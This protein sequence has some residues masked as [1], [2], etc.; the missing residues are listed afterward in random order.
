M[1]G[2]HGRARSIVVGL[3]AVLAVLALSIALLLI[4]TFR[5]VNDT[6][7]FVD[8]V[9]SIIT[10]PDVA[11]AIGDVAAAELVSSLAVQ[12]RIDDLLPGP[13]GAVAEPLASAAQSY[14]AEGT[15]ALLASEQFNTAWDA[16][17]TAG[18][19]ATI[20]LLSGSDTEAVERSGGVIVINVAPVASALVVQAAGYLS[21]LLGVD[22]DVSALT[23]DDV[24]GAVAGLEEQLGV[25]LP[26]DF[27]QIVLFESQNLAGA[28]EAYQ[29]T[30]TAVWLAPVAGILLAVLA[31]ALAANRR[32]VAMG[33]VVGVALLML[34][35]GLALRPLQSAILDAVADDGLDR[36]VATGLSTVFSSLQTG[37]VVVVAIG[38]AA[39]IL[40]LLSGRSAAARA[41]Q[42]AT[43]PNEVR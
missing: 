17:L 6:E 14:L 27:G 39:A 41:E 38:V 25:D 11:M 40:L 18:H 24:D 30:A 10:E 4:W 21:D 7:V 34:L 15:T 29:A 42:V 37:I 43:G 28:Q 31:V 5:T 1:T 12:D 9:G 23:D 16:S 26:A 20:A 35:V 3:M 13:L 33:V 19:Q 32:R 8:R 22:I 2:P 36:A